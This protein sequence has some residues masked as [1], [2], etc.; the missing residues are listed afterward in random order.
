MTDV[1]RLG[2]LLICVLKSQF[3]VVSYRR[4]LI[5]AHPFIMDYFIYDL[6]RGQTL[7]VVALSS[8]NE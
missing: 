6:R 5:T 3:L 7:P 8:I 1:S 2:R 4:T